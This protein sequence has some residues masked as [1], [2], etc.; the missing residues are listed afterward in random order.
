VAFEHHNMQTCN[1]NYQK[2]N[3]TEAQVLR[4][5]ITIYRNQKKKLVKSD[6]IVGYTSHIGIDY[7]HPTKFFPF[8]HKTD[9]Y[10]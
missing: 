1:S 4:Y 7:S 8:P 5:S 6:T 10:N 3:D 9:N 2:E